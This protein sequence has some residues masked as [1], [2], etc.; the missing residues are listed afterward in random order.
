MTA[1]RTSWS[2]DELL[3][4]EFPPPK[5]A[6]PGL[7]AEGLNVIVSPPKVGKSWLALGL[8]VAV[9][10]G[11]VALGKVSV[12]AGDVLY[13]GLEDTPRR[14][15]SRLRSVLDGSPPPAALTVSIEC[16]SIPSGG[17]D[18]IAG[19]LEAHKNARLVVVDV[20]AKVRGSVDRNTDVYTADYTAIG[21]LKA[22]ADRF[23]VAFLLVHH[24]RKAGAEDYLDSVSGSNGIAGAADA[25]IVLSRARNTAEAKLSITGRDVEEAEYALTFDPKVGT[26]T[27]LDVPAFTVDLSDER[28]R[29]L[30]VVQGRDGLGPKAI[31][32]DAD[33]SHDVVRQLV[34]KMVDA[35]QLDT[36]GQGHYFTPFTTFTAPDPAG[37]RCEQSE[38]LTCSRAL[39][40]DEG[41]RRGMCA[42]CRINLE[43]AS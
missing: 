11:G 36:D 40:T 32:E 14:L 26:W 13:L 30:E 25:V 5:W 20:F 12:D 41:K 38:C 31:A 15:Q 42:E 8:S 24:T 33:L 23:G 37:E 6:V 18:R 21:A 22:L 28:R 7:L 34:R 35:G 9:A 27:L 39:L 3:A 29:I 16:E 4:T 2:A 10:S 17:A 1:R 43:A 19:W